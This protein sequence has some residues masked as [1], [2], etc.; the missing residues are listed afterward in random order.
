[1]GRA[2]RLVRT[3]IGV[4]DVAQ[5]Q[6][7]LYLNVWTPA[8]NVGRR[9]VMVWFHGGAFILGSG[10]TV[11]YD[12]SQLAREGDVVVVTCNYRLGA[13]GYLNWRD[14]AK[15]T[16]ADLP[17]ANLGL[18][19][20]LAVLEWV[21]DHIECFGGDPGNVTVFG[22]SAGGMSVG[23]LLGTPVPK[24]S[25]TVPSSRAAPPTTWRAASR[26]LLR[27]DTSW[28]GSGS[29]PRAVACWSACRSPRS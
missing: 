18:R 11:L 6:N 16:G 8:A 4:T 10:S 23:T 28:T 9:P 20:Q 15:G 22:E 26:P 5:S 27:R 19:D 13:L 2:N 17:E 3:F 25:S 24:G 7:C 1:M 21:R 29:R 14:F 12:G